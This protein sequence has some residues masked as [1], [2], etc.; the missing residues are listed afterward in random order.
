[1]QCFGGTGAKTLNR[2]DK[3]VAATC[4]ASTMSASEEERVI[5]KV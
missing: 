1:M 5:W 3:S 4:Q 2:S